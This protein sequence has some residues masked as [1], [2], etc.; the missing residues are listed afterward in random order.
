MRGRITPVA[1]RAKFA[2]EEAL[3]ESGLAFTILR[4]T[5]FME[6]WIGIVGGPLAD[7]GHALV[8]GPGK[9]PINLVSVADVAAL[10]VIA[11]EDPTLRGETLE[12]GGPENVGFVTLAERLIEARGKP[13]LIRHV[14][15]PALRV[16][17]L[18]A[19]PFSPVFARHARAA[20][21]MNTTDCAFDGQL[22][23]RFPALPQTSL[24]SVLG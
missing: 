14:P 1:A 21:I 6:T 5:A 7:K 23:Q 12:I 18:L 17:S 19:R 20:V 3:R 4:P 15:L 10:A 13:A 22:R 9:N 11:L 2:A 8:F 16:M 24:R